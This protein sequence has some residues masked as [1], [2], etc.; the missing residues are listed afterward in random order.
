MNKN[1][2]KMR[3]FYLTMLPFRNCNKIKTS[4]SKLK[5]KEHS[6]TR[7]VIQ[8]MLKKKKNGSLKVRLN[9]KGWLLN[10]GEMLVSKR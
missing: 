8:E 3:I 2:F 7:S 5:L 1:A 4:P 9:Q 6:F 10:P